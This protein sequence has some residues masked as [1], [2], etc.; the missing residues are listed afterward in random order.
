MLC[1]VVLFLTFFV[2]AFLPLFWCF[3]KTKNKKNDRFG[4]QS[5]DGNPVTRDSGYRTCGNHCYRMAGRLFDN[6][7]LGAFLVLSFVVFPHYAPKFSVKTK[8]LSHLTS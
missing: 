5:G 8:S 4:W 1:P 3:S 7:V 6:N 2:F